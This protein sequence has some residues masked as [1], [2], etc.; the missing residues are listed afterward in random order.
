MEKL[1]FSAV[2]CV[3]LIFFLLFL[4]ATQ[5][6]SQNSVGPKT[7]SDYVIFAVSAVDHDSDFVAAL[8]YINEA[9]VL[10]SNDSFCYSFRGNISLSQKNYESALGDFIRA[11]WLGSKDLSDYLGRAQCYFFLGDY[12][13]SLDDL[14]QVIARRPFDAPA[15]LWRSR[16]KRAMGLEFESDIKTYRFLN[17]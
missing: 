4:K 7:K 11:I 16:V 12:C 13:S 17:G 3:I 14:N 2:I 5:V 9:I 15:Y 8:D 6:S 10:D 1:L